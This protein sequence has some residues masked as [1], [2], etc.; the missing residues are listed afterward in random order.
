MKN[1]FLFLLKSEYFLQNKSLD[2]GKYIFIFF[3]FSLFT[4]SL[5]EPPDKIKDFA[6][7]LFII[8]IPISLL[9]SSAFLF[10]RDLEDGTLET[11]FVAFSPIEIISAKF[12]ALSFNFCLYLGINLLFLVFL[13]DMEIG[14]LKIFAFSV[15]LSSILACSLAVLSS[16]SQCYFKSGGNFLPILIMPIL[17]PNV[18]LSGIIIADYLKYPLLFSMLGIDLLMIP[19]SMVFSS[20]LCKNIY[21][22]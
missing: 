17:I 1:R 14:N 4:A 3:L 5:I 15:F 16:V 20:Y 2:I 8:L 10:K 12:L 9:G 7:S 13:V 19:V 22:A 21:N 18:I 6:P 11:L